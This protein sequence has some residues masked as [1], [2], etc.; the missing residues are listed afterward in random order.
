MKFSEQGCGDVLHG[1][2]GEFFDDAADRES[3]DLVAVVDGQ[4]TTGIDAALTVPGSISGR[5]TDEHGGELESICVYVY[6]ADGDPTGRD[7]AFADE[8]GRYRLTGLASGA[9]KVKS[10]DCSGRYSALSE[11][12]DDA[13]TLEEAD[14][15]QVVFGEDTGG[16]GAALDV[17]EFSGFVR[18]L[19][20]PPDLTR[21]RAGSVVAVRFSLGGAF[22]LDLLRFSTYSHLADCADPSASTADY[23]QT[24]SVRGREFTY[25]APTDRY[26]YRWKTDRAWRGTCRVFSLFLPD[27][28]RQVW[29]D[30]RR[31]DTP[32]PSSWQS[33]TANENESHHVTPPRRTVGRRTAAAVSFSAMPARSRRCA[34]TASR[35][36]G[37]WWAPVTGSTAWCSR[38]LM[39]ARSTPSDFSASSRRRSTGHRSR[40]SGCTTCATRGRRSRGRPVC[41]RRR[42]TTAAERL[43]CSSSTTTSRDL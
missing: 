2:I 20:A 4:Q 27:G 29:L 1:A 9:Y 15:I 25:N 19:R 12:W 26:R 28:E 24:S 23:E 17:P 6:T 39:G 33:R 10:V 41:I 7:A 13:P 32:P 36:S 11:L 8:D 22:G 30:F 3:A 5:V 34:R 38:C 40:A 37:S 21:A 43:L 18:P 42:S 35:R 16:I 31:H 14:A